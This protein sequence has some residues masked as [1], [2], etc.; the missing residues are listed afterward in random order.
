[1][2][3]RHERSSKIESGEHRYNDHIIDAQSTQMKD[4]T[5]QKKHSS[6]LICSCVSSLLMD[7]QKNSAN[8]PL[9]PDLNPGNSSIPPPV[10]NIFTRELIPLYVS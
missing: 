9:N 1:M 7:R 10:V 3:R 2:N 5:S 4:F 8:K 6:M